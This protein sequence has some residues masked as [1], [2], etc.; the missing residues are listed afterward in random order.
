MVLR[1]YPVYLFSLFL[2]FS[3]SACGQRVKSTLAP[4]HSAS[5]VPVTDTAMVLLPL[6][7]YS[8]GLRPDDAMR[9]Q[10][11]VHG[12][13]VYY[14]AQ[15]GY[16]VP[17]QEDVV[18]CLADL[19]V[20]RLSRPGNSSYVKSN[21][22][23]YEELGN[24]WSDAMVKRISAIVEN[25]E[26]LGGQQEMDMKMV[27]LSPETLQKIGERF[28][29][30]YILRGRIA[31]Y[32][33]RDNPTLNPIR[34][35]ILPFVFDFGKATVLGVAHTE[36]YDT[37]QDMAIGAGAGAA[38]ASSSD[39]FWGGV[40]GAGAGYLMSKSGQAP[41]AVVRVGL[42]LQDANTGKVL[43]ANWVE[44]QVSSASVWAESSHRS[45]LDQAVEEAA[46]DLVSD[47]ADVLP[48]LPRVQV[49]QFVEPEPEPAPEEVAPP[50]PPV[51]E[52]PVL[53]IPKKDTSP[54]LWGS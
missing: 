43:W 37:W 35:G 18:Q 4:I 53:P 52:E 29:A 48:S 41:V 32:E 15:K 45:Q 51:E 36:K 5:R 3:L 27:G 24:G 6:A 38:L 49:T 2:L 14:L 28:G 25:N 1:R 26:R 33:I 50:P 31:E 47:L 42:A 17:L 12:A 34:K 22:L 19:D 9:R 8:T 7:D 40:T 54:E 44:K 39:A 13:L 10:S 20:I 11:K 23:I 30:R 46:Y 16:Y 21:E